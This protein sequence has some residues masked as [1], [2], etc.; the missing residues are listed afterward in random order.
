MKFGKYLID[1]KFPDW[2]DQY[3]DYDKLKK[4]IKELEKVI[5][6]YPMIMNSWKLCVCSE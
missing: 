5:S 3:L 2:A 6:T 4:I 1:N